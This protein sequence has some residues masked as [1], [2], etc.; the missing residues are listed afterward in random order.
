MGDICSYDVYDKEKL[1]LFINK[2]KEWKRLLLD[3][4]NLSVYKQV[5][6]MLWNDAIFRTF[7]EARRFTI[8]RN[9]PKLGL[10]GPLI[11]LLDKGFVESQ[12]MAIRRLTDRNFRDPEK[13][14]ISLIRLIDD[15]KKYANL[16]TRE[17]Y[18]CC[19]G[20]VYA[21][22]NS[23]HDA[24]NWVDWKRKQS[25]FDKMSGTSED[26]RDRSDKINISL[27]NRLEDNLKVCKAIRKYANKF[28]AHASDPQTNPEMSDEEKRITLDKLD[29][30]YRVIVRTASFL[31]A[32]LLYK[33]SLRG[34]PTP[35]YDH[36]KY[37][38]KP[39]VAKED[40]NKLSTFWQERFR[41]VEAWDVNL[42][43]ED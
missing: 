38:D 24:P 36:L 7:N 19:K 12:V 11:R 2:R 31:G 18:I 10:N 21:E 16:I 14:V 6:H 17:N 23:M 13:A 34:I 28:I 9:S 30:C 42:W 15:I 43:E 5:T 8:E 25:N 1:L 27:I 37:L 41:E 32:V 40:M 35:Q 26:K 29:E 22:P 20:T 39:M 3:G 4:R 33:Y